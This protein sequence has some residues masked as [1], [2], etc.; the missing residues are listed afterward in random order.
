MRDP[1]NFFEPYEKLPAGHENQL[2]RA[3]LVVLR[4]V[5]LAHSVWLRLVSESR[6][7]SAVPL[8]HLQELPPASFTTQTGRIGASRKPADG[9]DDSSSLFKA[10]SV[11]LGGDLPPDHADAAPSDRRAIFD[12]VV[13]YEDDLAL[14][15]EAKLDG[16]FDERQARQITIGDTAWQVD[17]KRARLHWRDIIDAWRELIAREL[18][19]G[20]ERKVLEDFMWLIH[21]HFPRLQPFSNI[22]SCHGDSYLLRLRLKALLEEIGDLSSEI[23]PTGAITLLDKATAVK[24]A[25]L[26]P[27]SDAGEIRLRLWPGDTLE[28]AKALYSSTKRV[29]GLLRLQ[30][31][32]WKVAP[33]FH[34]GHM[35]KGFVWTNGDIDVDAYVQYW[36][37][38]VHSAKQIPRA[39][40]SAYLDELISRGIASDT[41]RQAFKRDFTDTKR[42][43]A[44]PR[45]GLRV[46]RSWRLESAAQLDSHKRF[47]SA[48]RNEINT[49]LK[50]LGE[51]LI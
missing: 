21:N 1:L 34:F 36:M 45:P 12:G 32:G 29:S 35:A 20:A 19:S 7:D 49:V 39:E 27:D 26:E 37:K 23:R 31:R 8:P 46:E 4:L 10:V 43:S 22:E 9:F 50:I 51:P 44:T 33:N 13:R 11:L 17:P 24:L 42:S 48:V 40:W 3:F 25:A 14:V 6:G 41:D 5:P 47:G 18:V 15:V 16:R 30:D 38:N 2:T 28:Q